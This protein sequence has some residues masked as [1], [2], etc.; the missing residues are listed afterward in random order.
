MFVWVYELENKRIEII[1]TISI[2]TDVYIIFEKL[3][4]YQKWT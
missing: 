1:G 4:K 2:T 3:I